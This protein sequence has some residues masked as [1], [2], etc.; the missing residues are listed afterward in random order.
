MSTREVAIRQTFALLRRGI[1]RGGDLDELVQGIAQATG[2]IGLSLG[3]GFGFV[4]ESRAVDIPPEWMEEHRADIQLDPAP[5]FL[6]A[7]GPFAVYNVA[8]HAKR[9]EERWP[10]LRAFRRRFTDAAIM[11]PRGGAS[12]LYMAAYRPRG[13][14]SF[15]ERELA[16]LGALVPWLALAFETRTAV[17]AFNAPRDEREG[18]ALARMGAFAVLGPRSE[19]ARFSP[20]AE[21]LLA[22]RFGEFGA[23]GRR[24]VAAA[25]RLGFERFVAG[26][27]QR[28]F[29]LRGDVAVELALLPREGADADIL[30]RFVAVRSDPPA[31]SPHELILSPRQRAVARR[32][33]RGE[34]LPAI[35]RALGISAEVAKTHLKAVYERL[36][37]RSRVELAALYAPLLR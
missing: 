7:H 36:G 24:V 35:A 37:V 19:R 14:A 21:R 8:R 23:R 20:A 30:A 15:D 2:S 3:S 9:E 22:E 6:E 5:A 1:V 25:I 29:L 17:E 28:R 13:T 32:A 11:K 27:G 12:P 4:P 33:A 31:L 26:A 34:S 10:L 16:L 18:D